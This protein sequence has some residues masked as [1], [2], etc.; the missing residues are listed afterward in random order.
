MNTATNKTAWSLYC[1]GCDATAPGEELATLCAAC[2]QPWLTAVTLPA[3]RSSG[4]DTA[5]TGL[6]RYRSV[7]PVTADEP[8]VRLGEGWTPMFEATMLARELGVG[9]LWIKDEGQNP[10]ASEV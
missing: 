5:A 8:V 1:S 4:I 2:G 7:L 10:T 3:H 6:W 9:R